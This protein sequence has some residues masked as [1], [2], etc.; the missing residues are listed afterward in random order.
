MDR[1][2]EL[3]PLVCVKCSTPIPAGPEE[4]AWVC[5]QCGQGMALDPVQG[6]QPLQIFYSATV[7]AGQPGKPYWVSSGQVS[8]H[9]ETFDGRN[10]ATQ[11][12][13]EASH[14]W[15]Q[16]RLFIIPAYQLPLEAFLARSIELLVRP[17]AL[18]PG[19]AAPFEPPTL[20]LEDIQPAAEF[21]VAAIEAGR[22]DRMKKLGFTLKLS[23][24]ALWIFSE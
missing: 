11:S 15:S 19:P 23:L 10:H 9:R 13:Q 4:V 16:P 17:P 12:D 3:V 2:I 6:L 7:P 20:M 24:P 8:L 14:F 1:P 5:G 22:K 18:H 21:V